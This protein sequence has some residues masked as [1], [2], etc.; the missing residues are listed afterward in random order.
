MAT[1]PF[2]APTGKFADNSIVAD[3][4][5]WQLRYLITASIAD[6]FKNVVRIVGSDTTGSQYERALVWAE[7]A[8]FNKATYGGLLPN[9]SVIFDVY[10][11]NIFMV[12]SSTVVSSSLV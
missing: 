1:L 12:S 9:G 7:T 11:K 4:P 10:G 2:A 8:S 3:G 5:S 6:P